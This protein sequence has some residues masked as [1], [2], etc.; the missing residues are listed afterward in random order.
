[1]DAVAP[2]KALMIT[3]DTKKNG[4]GHILPKKWEN[5]AKEMF[6]A[7]LLEKMPDV[8]KVYIE[9]FPSGVVPK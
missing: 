2:M 3:P 1:M 7:G 8:K 4:L 6:K 9:K 5:V